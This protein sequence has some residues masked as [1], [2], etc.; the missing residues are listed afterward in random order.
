MRNLESALYILQI[1]VKVS[2]KR[3]KPVL[4]TFGLWCLPLVTT[5]ER[6]VFLFQV[7]L[8]RAENDAAGPSYP[9]E[10]KTRCMVCFGLGN[11][12]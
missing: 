8:G 5:A 7:V 12:F 1:T 6:T 2:G 4:P 3:R 11:T 10:K 9:T